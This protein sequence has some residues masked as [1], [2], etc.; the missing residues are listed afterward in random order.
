MAIYK[1]GVPPRTPPC[2]PHTPSTLVPRFRK[3]AREI[4]N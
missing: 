1:R 4:K 3:K 2:V